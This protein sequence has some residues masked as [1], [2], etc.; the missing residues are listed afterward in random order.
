MADTNNPINRIV[1]YGD[2]FGF[3]LG[4]L[5]F[6]VGKNLLQYTDATFELRNNTGKIYPIGVNSGKVGTTLAAN[7]VYSAVMFRSLIDYSLRHGARMSC[8]TIP[9]N[10]ETYVYIDYS[11]TMSDKVV[12]NDSYNGKKIEIIERT[13]ANL[14]TDVYNGG[15]YINANYVEGETCYVVLKIPS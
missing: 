8:Y 11:A 3:A 14:M 6:G 10:N 12:L 1:T 7:Q 15:F 2:N 13:N 4:F 9:F 5:P